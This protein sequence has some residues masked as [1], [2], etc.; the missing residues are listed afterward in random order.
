MIHDHTEDIAR[1]EREISLGHSP[2]VLA[3]ARKNLTLLQMHLK[4]SQDLPAEGEG[5]TSSP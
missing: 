4:M 3:S 1:T 5:T 2:I